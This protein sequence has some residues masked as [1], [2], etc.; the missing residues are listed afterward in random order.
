MNTPT[1]TQ[2][3]RPSQQTSAR[4]NPAPNQAA[5]QPPVRPNW[6]TY[7]LTDSLVAS[8]LQLVAPGS[9]RKARRP[10]R[11]TSPAAA[12]WKSLLQFLK[13]FLRASSIA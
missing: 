9:K 3:T 7:V 2:P 8:W 13:I 10:A 4:S 1:Q 11:A 6:P 5:T 12:S